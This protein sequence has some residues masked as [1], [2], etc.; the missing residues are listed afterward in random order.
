LAD[1]LWFFPPLSA[2]FWFL[3]GITMSIAVIGSQNV[4]SAEQIRKASQKVKVV[5]SR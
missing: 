3:A 2:N 5:L 1:T 4:E